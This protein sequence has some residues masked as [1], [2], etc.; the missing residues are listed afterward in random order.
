M[1]QDNLIELFS[2]Y[3]DYL[4]D[5]EKVSHAGEICRLVTN[6]STLRVE[7]VYPQC[8][9]CAP[10][11]FVDE[12]MI[13]LDL[14]RVLIHEVLSSSPS[15]LLYDGLVAVLSRLLIRRFQE[16]KMVG[17]LWAAAVEGGMNSFAADVAVAE[18]LR[19][20]DRMGREGNRAPSTPFCLETFLDFA[21]PGPPS[22]ATRTGAFANRKGE[23]NENR[24]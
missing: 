11:H 19:D 18:R 1:G 8:V 12:S 16:E 21:P 6:I 20:L 13:K 10:H 9:G 4:S 17:R 14:A 3:G 2:P 24:A 23:I 15:S 7:I 22:L 5:R